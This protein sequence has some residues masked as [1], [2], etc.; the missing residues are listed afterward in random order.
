MQKIII[1]DFTRF[2]NPKIVCT[3]GIDL[4]TGQCIRPMPYFDASFE[5]TDTPLIDYTARQGKPIIISTGIADEA[6]IRSVLWSDT[7]ASQFH[8]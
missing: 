5:I 1:T 4:T 8:R 2:S 6:D 3:A 7:N